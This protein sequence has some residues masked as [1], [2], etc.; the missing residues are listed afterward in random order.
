MIYICIHWSAEEEQER[1]VFDF[2][3]VFNPK[4]KHCRRRRSMAASR[5]GSNFPI[6]F[7]FSFMF[8]P[9]PFVHLSI[10]ETKKFSVSFAPVRAIAF[11]SEFPLSLVGVFLSIDAE[12]ANGAKKNLLLFDARAPPPPPPPRPSSSQPPPN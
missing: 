5:N 12:E 1:S 4:S 6:S 7:V 11:L 10:C 3:F 2:F 8:V 9:N